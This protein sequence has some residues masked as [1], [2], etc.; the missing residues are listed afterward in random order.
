MDKF[1]NISYDFLLKLGGSLLIAVIGFFAARL[2]AYLFGKAMK[3][4]NV[5]ISLINFFKR[6]IRIVCYIIIVISALSNLG[7]ST[8]GIIASFSAVA[9]AFALALKDSLSDIASG[10]VILFTRPFKTNDFIEFDDHRGY[11]EK[12]DLMHTY[13]RTYDDTNV[14][15]PNS[16]I[17]T[18]KVNNF[19]TN[20][21]IRVQIFIPIAYEADFDKVKE[22]VV[23]RMK[24]TDKVILDNE[25]F[26]PVVRLQSYQESSIEAIARCWVNFK[27][28]WAVYYSLTENI[29]KDLEA[30]NLVIPF[31]QLDVH[32]DNKE[33]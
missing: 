25:K 6:V 13:I 8:T 33:Q 5:D 21:E 17:T 27:D 18:T 9:A 26:T 15:I 24:K 31:N 23:D 19:T 28:Y 7:I 29:K 1:L 3:K 22:I 11:V 4:T 12:I 2:I 30:N 14:I 10:V 16:N 32:I 20:P